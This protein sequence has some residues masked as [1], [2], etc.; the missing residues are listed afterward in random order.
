METYNY[1]LY[2]FRKEKGLS[3][4]KM[5]KLC[6]ISSF[7]YAAIEKGYIKPTKKKAAKIS[8]ALG[9]DF[10][11]YLI[12]E[13]SYPSELPERRSKIARFGYRFISHPITVIFFFILGLVST[14]TMIFGFVQSDAI[15]AN[16]R[17]YFDEEVLSFHDQLV[18]VGEPYFSLTAQDMKQPEIYFV[19]HTEEAS[20][21]VSI[22]AAS[23]DT[24]HLNAPTFRAVYRSEGFRLM[25][26]YRWT[27]LDDE[28]DYPTSWLAEVLQS[29]TGF[30]SSGSLNYREEKGDPVWDLYGQIGTEDTPMPEG[31]S[32]LLAL[33][34]DSLF[35]DFDRLIANSGIQTNLDFFNLQKKEMEAMNRIE[36]IDARNELC[37]FLGLV[38][39]GGAFFVAI[40]GFL[41]S[42]RKGV[43]EGLTYRRSEV[44]V[45]MDR[46][47]P[48][49]YRFG[50]FL[51][52]TII[53]LVG[54]VLVFIGSLRL[55][56][57]SLA[58]F[59]LNMGNVLESGQAT[60]LMSTFM[61]GMFLLYFIDFDL[62]LDDKRLFRDIA[63]YS[64]V[65]L[66]LYGIEM[67]VYN[68]INDGSV[69]SIVIDYVTIPNPFGS[70]AC[71]F[72][73]MLFLFYKPKVIKTQRGLLIYRLLASIPIGWVI[74]SWLLFYGGN[75]LF[76]MNMPIPVR[77]IFSC[78]KPAFTFL[79]ISY[80]VSLYFL[81]LHYTRKYGEENAPLYF[82]GN[83]FL[84]NKNF[85]VAILVA[86]I[87]GVEFILRDNATAHTLGLGHY[88]NIVL[89]IPLL[90][91]YHPHKGKR[92]LGVDMTTMTLYIIA[93]ST[94][95]LAAA[96]IILLQLIGV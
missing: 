80:L 56:L 63:L 74:T 2:R 91:F 66:C 31:L 83:R 54:I 47:M 9:E 61:V 23:Y 77:Y 14:A 25:I 4:Y 7:S 22:R 42:E 82:N 60:N 10:S 81:R 45:D 33:G 84:W 40:F 68:I 76:D 67:M 95:Y 75:A 73:T 8:E 29:D 50:P 62:F 38:A 6:H 18:E 55:I 93:L 94:A 21:Y 16:N 89:L 41:Y 57:L 1:H 12:E 71:Y 85:L 70:V 64:I 30:T 5:A 32:R 69:L 19:E 44:S 34:A 65:F 92:N 39:A 36:P 3:R 35:A 49:D 43:V 51:P 88:S 58:F 96:L 46:R 13:P 26:S 27:R 37:R 90:L 52:E 24:Q 79:A 59:T 17:A 53:E 28:T 20:R 78:E 11:R 87:G 86:V 48:T 15:R 72:L